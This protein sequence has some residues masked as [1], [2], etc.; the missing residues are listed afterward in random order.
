MVSKS[1]EICLRWFFIGVSLCP[2]MRIFINSSLR[3]YS[4][5]RFALPFV[6]VFFSVPLFI[7]DRNIEKLFFRSVTSALPCYQMMYIIFGMKWVFV[8]VVS[9]FRQYFWG[10]CPFPFPLLS[11]LRPCP[12]AKVI[13]VCWPIIGYFSIFIS[14]PYCTSFCVL[15]FKKMFYPVPIFNLRKFAISMMWCV[16]ISYCNFWHLVFVLRAIAITLLDIVLISAM[17]FFRFLRYEMATGPT[18][19]C[20]IWFVSPAPIAP[21][22]FFLC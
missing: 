10:I 9:Y 15:L 17:E 14:G 12:L 13:I 19:F 21:V 7:T 11:F 18:P 22:V 8:G 1:Y 16:G 6:V 3:W 4:L 2:R 5:L 20:C